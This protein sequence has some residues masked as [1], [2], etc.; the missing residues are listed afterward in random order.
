MRSSSCSR[1]SEGLQ[2]DEANEPQ[3]KTCATDTVGKRRLSFRDGKTS[4][5]HW[6]DNC[7]IF[8]FFFKSLVSVCFISVKLLSHGMHTRAHTQGHTRTH[9]R[10]TSAQRG[11]HQAGAPTSS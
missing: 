4:R 1:R 2:Q 5:S 6:N 11:G 10:S 7:G 9:T 3:C 8:F